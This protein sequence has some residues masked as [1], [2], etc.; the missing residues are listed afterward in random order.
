MRKRRIKRWH[1]MLQNRTLSQDYVVQDDL[2]AQIAC[3]LQ[4]SL[5]NPTPA[6][7]HF[8]RGHG[9]L[10]GRE[11]I[12]PDTIKQRRLNRQTKAA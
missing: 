10:F 3:G 1:Q 12:K 5:D 7:I 6:D 8:G 4:V 11:R 9:I 2:E